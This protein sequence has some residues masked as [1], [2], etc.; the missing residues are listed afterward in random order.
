MTWILTFVY[1]FALE[2]ENAVRDVGKRDHIRA[3][4]QQKEP[5]GKQVSSFLL[6]TTNFVSPTPDTHALSITRMCIAH[7]DAHY[8]CAVIMSNT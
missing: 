4:G 3:L 1:Y 5:A 6:K 8:K 2:H 7:F